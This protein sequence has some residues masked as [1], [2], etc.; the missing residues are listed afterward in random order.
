MSLIQFG[1]TLN[2]ITTATPSSGYLIAYD[3]DGVLKEKDQYGVISTFLKGTGTTNYLSKWSGSSLTSSIIYDNSS[4][5]GIGTSNPNA[6]MHI[7]NSTGSASFIIEDE[8]ND[9]TPFLVD[10]NGNV[11]IGTSSTTS[12][13]TVWNGD[14]AIARTQTS[15][16]T[17]IPARLLLQGDYNNSSF[18]E[19][20]TDEIIN[21]ISFRS[22]GAV[23]GFGYDI[24]QSSISG[25]GGKLFIT[26]YTGGIP[27]LLMSF[28]DNGNIGVGTSS[29]SAKF[30]I[31]STQSGVF[32]LEDTTQNAGFVLTSDS[33]GVGTWQA[34][35]TTDT[36]SDVLSNGNITSGYDIVVDD[37]IYFGA[38]GSISGSSNGIEIN[39]A[40]GSSL[41]VN[42]G[43]TAAQIRLTAGASNG[44]ILTSD[45]S[46]NATW[47]SAT[48][49][50]ANFANTD[51]TF[52]SNRLHD[53][54]G[55]IFAM[56]TDGGNYLES[57]YYML[58]SY[59]SIGY[60]TNWRY[61]TNDGISDYTNNIK[62]LDIGSA[63][64]IV[65]DNQNDFDFIVRGYN[66]SNLLYIDSA[67]D[68]I[69]IGT[70]N[71]L[72][73]LH[74]DNG[75][76]NLFYDY[77]SLASVSKLLLSGS[78][79]DLTLM[80]VYDGTSSSIDFGVRGSTA[81][82]FTGYGDNNTAFIYVG[83]STNG[84]NIINQVGTSDNY[85]RFYAGGDVTDITYPDI[86]IHGDGSNRGYVGFGLTGPS[87]KVDVDGDINT[88]TLY[89]VGAT[90]GYTGTFSSDGQ[91]ITVLGGIITNVV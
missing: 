87:Y 27:K 86:H 91:I 14:L 12:K 78:N 24:A 26:G 79:D 83:A 84:L 88:S 28:Q 48:L 8:S 50:S 76:S 80:G 51:L 9:T 42:R 63:S 6:I 10:T 19:D 75:D 15:T 1:N 20:E 17:A 34:F 2:I 31:L 33:N 85:I 21:A 56:T 70:S 44:Y 72:Y 58:T 22:D 35:S 64:M 60:N 36:L 11:G 66:D 73:K 74:I 39:V 90:A 65:N 68:R 89:R 55:N 37:I 43:I 49:S 46:G 59:N 61:Y 5:V 30:H 62:R 4:R 18:A 13:L 77:S 7:I 25:S 82:L 69:G 47:K 41:I 53:T 71:P 23:S 81:S 3:L 38:T 67:N 40:T 29:P 32:R 54:N 52:T 57:W 45:A 16:G